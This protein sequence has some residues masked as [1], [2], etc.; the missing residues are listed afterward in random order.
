MNTL[1]T[2]SLLHQFGL[3]NDGTEYPHKIVFDQAG[4]IVGNTYAGTSD[5]GSVYEL[6]PSGE[7]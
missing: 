4:N 1:W 6:R 5:D 7:G 2:Y 3:G